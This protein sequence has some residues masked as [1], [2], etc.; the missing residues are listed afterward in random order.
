MS[1][2]DLECL[3][4]FTTSLEMINCKYGHEQLWDFV[5]VAS[6]TLLIR[7]RH[8]REDACLSYTPGGTALLSECGD[9]FT[10]NLWHAKPYNK[11]SK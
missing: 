6:G 5:E 3:S 8:L 11:Y 9:E 10:S 4:S 1:F 7:L 2:L